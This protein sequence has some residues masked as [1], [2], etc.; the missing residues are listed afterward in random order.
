MARWLFVVIPIGFILYLEFALSLSKLFNLF[1][2]TSKPNKSMN[3][4]VGYGTLLPTSESENRL[5][6]S[7]V[8]LEETLPGKHNDWCNAAMGDGFWKHVGQ[9]KAD[10]TKGYAKGICERLSLKHNSLHFYEDVPRRLISKKKDNFI[11]DSDLNI[12][13][14]KR[15]SSLKQILHSMRGSVTVIESNANLSMLLDACIQ[16]KKINF[17]EHQHSPELWIPYHLRNNEHSSALLNVNASNY[18]GGL[19]YYAIYPHA[20]AVCHNVPSAERLDYAI[21]H[22]QSS[23]R[24]LMKTNIWNEGIN[25]IVPA[26]HPIVPLSSLSMDMDTSRIAHASFLTVDYDNVAKYPKD[27][28]IPYFA[29][30]RQKQLAWNLTRPVLLMLCSLPTQHVRSQILSIYSNISI[31]VVVNLD[32]VLSETYESL[33]ETSKF[34]FMVRGDTVSS[35]RFFSLIDAGCIP[36]VV[37][38]WIYLPFQRLIKYSL[39]TV[40]ARENLVINS[41][42]KFL[43]HL[44]MIPSKKIETMQKYLQ[45]AR[46]L[47]MYDSSY[48]LNPVTLLFIESKLLR[49]CYNYEVKHPICQNFPEFLE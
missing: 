49:L 38:D 26:S 14:K 2:S 8:L 16:F 1:V 9:S 12:I 6:D 11:N 5:W 46:L 23:L 39:F 48:I 29:D 3:Q 32:H 18:K 24:S 45:Q 10:C 42:H 15:L 28:V 20:H 43:N 34:C 27:L 40:F 25:I 47:L 41:P 44:R 4:R 19:V 31:D 22:I 35:A 30:V 33:L 21:N 36:V 37:S 17:Y 7:C 13:L